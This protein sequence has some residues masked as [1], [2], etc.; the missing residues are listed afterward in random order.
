[1]NEGTTVKIV[2]QKLVGKSPDEKSEKTHGNWFESLQRPAFK[3]AIKLKQKPATGQLQFYYHQSF[4]N[5]LCHHHLN[6]D[7]SHQR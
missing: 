7:D 6:Y 1:M 4:P 3:R 5:F 2:E